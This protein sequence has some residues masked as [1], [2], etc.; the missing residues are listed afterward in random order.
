VTSGGGQATIVTYNSPT[1]VVANITQPITDTIPNDPTNTPVPAVSG[2]WSMSTPVTTV[3]GLNHLEGLTVSI[4]GDG[5]VFPQQIVTNGQVTLQEPSSLIHV[6]LPFIAQLQTLYLDP[7]QPTVQGKRK[8]IYNVSVRCES[9]RGI[10]VGTN[11]P[12]QST[13]PDN[14][15]VPWTNLQEVKERNALVTAGS[16]IP[17]FTGDFYINLPATWDVKGQVAVQQQNPLPANVLAMITN[18]QIGDTPG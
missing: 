1:Q 3:S 10:E 9:T 16:A 13:Q 18:F 5:G 15:D 12:D 2:Y 6:G 11:Q 14:A 7:G 4:L 17:L 8:N